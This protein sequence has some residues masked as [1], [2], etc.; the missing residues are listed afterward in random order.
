MDKSEDPKKIIL[1][2][3]IALFGPIV[4]FILYT[5]IFKKEDAPKEVWELLT[6]LLIAIVIY[7]V[8]KSERFNKQLASR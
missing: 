2:F 3:H 4:L 8:S 5:K 1:K 6:V 7:K